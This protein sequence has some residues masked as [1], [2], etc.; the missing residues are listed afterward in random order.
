[1]AQAKEQFPWDTLPSAENYDADLR[2]DL[3]A[4]E[5]GAPN[6][7]TRVSQRQVTWREDPNERARKIWLWWKVR[8][9]EVQEYRF[10]NVLTSN[11]LSTKQQRAKKP[12]S[13]NKNKRI[14]K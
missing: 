4:R 10:F 5:G 13:Q 12:Q 1:M 3:D 8:V 9:H 6:P 14:K 7:A 11:R 2:K